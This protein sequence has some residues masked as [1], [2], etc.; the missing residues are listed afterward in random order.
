MPSKKKL[1]DF[2]ERFNKVIVETAY[3]IKHNQYDQVNIQILRVK[4]F[5]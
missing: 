1:K 3:V 5:L 2:V 4:Q